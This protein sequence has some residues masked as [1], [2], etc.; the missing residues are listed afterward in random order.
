MNSA[1]SPLF[2]QASLALSPAREENPEEEVYIPNLPASPHASSSSV[3]V[4]IVPAEQHLFLQG[5]KPA[6]YETRPPSLLRGCLVLRILKPARV[7]SVSLHFKGI[8]RTEWPEGIPPKR[9]HYAEVNELINH[10]WPFYHV[11][12]HTFNFGADF[13][14]PLPSSLQKNQEDI[15]HFSLN[16]SWQ[17][18]QNPVDT[19]KGFAASLINRAT[20]RGNSPSPAP[21]IT[22]VTSFQDLT[23]ALSTGSASEANSAAT[24]STPKPGYFMPGDY[25]Y[26]FE[27][28]LPASSPESVDANFGRVFYALEA[29]IIRTGAFKTNLVARLPVSVVRIPSDNSVEENEPIFIERDWEDQLRYEILVGSKSIVLDTYVPISFKF[30]PLYGKVALHRIRVSITENCNYYCRN[31]TVHRAEP[32]RKFLLLEHKAKQNKSLLS[33]SGCL[34]DDGPDIGSEDDEILPRE[35]EFQMF[36]P[37]TINK[38]Y[39]FAMHPDTSFE[40]IQ[41]DHWIKISLRISRKDPSNPEKR[42]HFEIS[43]DSPIHL[44]SPY[45]A[46]CNTLLP[47]YDRPEQP[48]PLPQYAP[49]SPPMSPDVTAIDQSQ[50]RPT[51]NPPSFEALTSVEGILP[52][53]Y[54]K[55]DPATSPVR[56]ENTGSSKEFIPAEAPR[57]VADTG[58]D[59]SGIKDMLSRQ[60]DS[61]HSESQAAS[62]NQ[63]NAKPEDAEAHLMR[64]SRSLR[65]PE[66]EDDLDL[67]DINSFKSGP[68]SPELGPLATRRSSVVS[69]DDVDLPLDQTLPLL[70]LNE[71][72]TEDNL[73]TSSF[74]QGRRPSA[75]K[76]TSM[77][78]LMDQVTFGHTGV[79]NHFFKNP[80]LKKHYH[81][82]TQSD[83]AIHKERQKSFG[84]VPSSELPSSGSTE[85][86]ST[87]S[88]AR[89]EII[90]EV[91]NSSGEKAH[92]GFR[93]NV[94][95]DVNEPVR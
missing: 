26:N 67:S 75:I 47:A 40:T 88:S 32:T 18:N 63:Q 44:C 23:T 42:K 37:S 35:L 22:P 30:I 12:S 87:S 64:Q 17:S 34:T 15:S 59:S 76:N 45:A 20:T 52:P 8:Q 71:G 82:E 51:V 43:I 38:K 53:A 94:S 25:V 93:G 36:V 1:R 73:S 5:Y 62:G 68:V 85:R 92:E 31:K 33:K 29:N 28:P 10:T 21:A 81:E 65:I 83:A 72:Y 84:V 6:E 95:K 61:T 91:T 77:A 7:K 60:F 4:F 24:A 11:D 80:R 50:G 58:V 69:A 27:H 55:E 19:A 13:V 48:E 46:H 14:R 57:T 90:S 9:S 2:P 70:T 66:T 41:C 54:E 3:Q 79:E 16:D 56:N 39:N 78:D 89:S 86:A 49:S 74:D